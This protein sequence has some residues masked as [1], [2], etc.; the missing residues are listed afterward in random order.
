M[1]NKQTSSHAKLQRLLKEIFDPPLKDTTFVMCGLVYRIV[2]FG[3]NL[4]FIVFSTYTYKS[5]Q[6]FLLLRVLTV[7]QW[8]SVLL[9]FPSYVNLFCDVK[10]QEI[11][12]DKLPFLSLAIVLL[13]PLPFW[14]L[15]E[16]KYFFFYLF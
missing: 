12:L 6:A 13:V 4:F 3:N 9:V 8:T 14:F 1:T 2:T 15:P 11:S 16:S 5:R 7:S 10:W